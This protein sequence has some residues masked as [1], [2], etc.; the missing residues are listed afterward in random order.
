[1]ARDMADKVDERER[2]HATKEGVDCVIKNALPRNSTKLP[3]KRVVSWL[4]SNSMNI[5]QSDKEGMF[6]LLPENLLG[7]KSDEAIA[8]NFKVVNFDPKKRRRE[9]LKLLGDLNLEHLKK[10]TSKTDSGLTSLTADF[11]TIATMWIYTQNK[12]RKHRRR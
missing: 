3:F 11:F 5:L 4:K 2:D 6:V 10:I 8:K 1:M 9:A 12:G 7:E